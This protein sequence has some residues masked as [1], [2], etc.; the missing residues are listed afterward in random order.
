MKATPLP[1][2]LFVILV[3]SCGSIGIEGQFLGPADATATALATSIRAAPTSTPDLGA[4]AAIERAVSLTLTA[5]APTPT[6]TLPPSPRAFLIAFPGNEV[7][8]GWEWPEGAVVHLAIDDLT[9]A[10]SPDLEGVG[11]A[12]VTMW[13]NTRVRFEFATQYD[14]KV[15]DVVTLTDGTTERTHVVRNLSVTAVGAASDTVAG[16]A[17]PG[18]P[19]DVWPHE[20]DQIATVQVTAGDDGTWLANFADLF[21]LVAGTSGRSRI[22]DE[23]GSATAV[24][25]TAPAPP[26]SPTAVPTTAIPP[27]E[28]PLPTAATKPAPGAGLSTTANLALNQSTR[29]SNSLQSP[30]NMAVDG[31]VSTGWGSGDGAPQWIEIDLGAPAKITRIRLLVTQ[32]PY[33]DTLHRILVRSVNGDFSEAFRFEQYTHTGQWL[34]FTPEEPLQDVQI[35][36]IET[37]NSPSW[38]AWLEIQVLGER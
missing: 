28:T 10:A 8:E 21:D 9:T 6:N 24:D 14:L 36:R 2:L 37:L 31:D 20:F 23:A 33:G 3:M 25:W 5:A 1:L 32:Y 38:V 12:T 30:A 16:T 18:A 19:V 22:L 13:G 34:A 29:A 27:T 4:T 15:G 7:V 17:D 35:V 11:M 26:P